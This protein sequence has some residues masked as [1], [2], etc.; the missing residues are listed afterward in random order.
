MSPCTAYLVG[1]QV[2]DYTYSWVFDPQDF[3]CIVTDWN[4]MT[5]RGHI[6]AKFVMVSSMMGSMICAVASWAFVPVDI[7]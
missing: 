1:L 3:L 2:S 7:N 6:S 4:A 5:L